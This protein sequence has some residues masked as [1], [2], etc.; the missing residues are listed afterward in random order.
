MGIFRPNKSPAPCTKE[1]RR[2][3][4]FGTVISA[5]LC[6][7]R[8]LCHS[9]NLGTSSSLNLLRWCLKITMRTDLMKSRNFKIF[10]YYL[11]QTGKSA[12]F[13]GW[14]ALLVLVYNVELRKS[15]KFNNSQKS[16]KIPENPLNTPPQEGFDFFCKFQ[17]SAIPFLNRLDLWIPKMCVV[18]K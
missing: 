9:G 18:K 8:S 13:G 1:A 7:C 3:T 14:L 5:E 6:W 15:R 11:V 16:P 17:S 12:A 2:I 4:K 10:S